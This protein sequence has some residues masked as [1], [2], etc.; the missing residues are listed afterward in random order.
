M[1]Y[2]GAAVVPS[3][4]DPQRTRTNIVAL[5][6]AAAGVLAVD[7]VAAAAA[8]GVRVSAMGRH[9]VRAVTHLDVDDAGTE[10][11]ARVLAEVLGEHVARP[12]TE[13]THVTGATG[14]VLA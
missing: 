2:D 1:T 14:G 3:A 4:V 7:V 6:L 12:A 9:V 5:D 8:R 13:A 10:R 11:A